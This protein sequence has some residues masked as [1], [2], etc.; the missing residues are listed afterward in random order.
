MFLDKSTFL[1][2]AFAPKPGQDVP[3]PLQLFPFIIVFVVFYF[4]A[5]RPQAKQAREQEN[6]RSSLKK[7]DRVV[8]N[9]GVIGTILSVKE[10]DRVITIRS[11]E[12][13]LEILRSAVSGLLKDEAKKD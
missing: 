2:F 3:L 11:D 4:I 6:L 9:G 5:I 12:T 13:K 7:G 8:T 1:L 10:N